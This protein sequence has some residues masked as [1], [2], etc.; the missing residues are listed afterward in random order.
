MKAEIVSHDG[1]DK[2]KEVSGND[3]PLVKL[4]KAADA[5]K[6]RTCNIF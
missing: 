5:E 3:D 4:N 1:M 6:K 2:K